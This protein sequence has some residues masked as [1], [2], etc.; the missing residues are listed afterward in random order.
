MF[1]KRKLYNHLYPC[2][3]F[4]FLTTVEKIWRHFPEVPFIIIWHI[5]KE[6]QLSNIKALAR[7]IHSVNQVLGSDCFN[8]LI[9]AYFLLLFSHIY[10]LWTG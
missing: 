3:I 10:E 1:V 5:F 9:F 6:M 8:F 4:I 2:L 7:M